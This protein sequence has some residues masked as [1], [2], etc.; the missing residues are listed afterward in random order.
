MR[1]GYLKSFT[2]MAALLTAGSLAAKPALDSG[3]GNGMVVQRGQPIIFSG[4]AKPS[5]TVSGQFGNLEASTTAGAD[6]SFVLSFPPHEASTKLVNLRVSDG[7][8]TEAVSGIMVGDVFLCS[9]Q[10]NMEFAVGR[11]LNSWGEMQRANDQK[12]RLRKIPK[13]TAGRPQRQV[14]GSSVWS[15]ADGSS[16]EDFSAACYY[17]GKRL[18]AERPDVPVGLIHSNWG[19]SAASAWL[20]PEA[21]EALY[22]KEPAFLLAQFQDD[23]R[24][25]LQTF[26]AVWF[27][28]WRSKDNGRT[29]WTDS[30][31][32]NW[33]AVPG[34]TDWNQ[35]K[36]SGLDKNPK[37]NVWLRQ[38]LTLTR[39]QAAAGG[40]LSLGALD[41]LDHTWVNGEVIGNTFG[42]GT[43]REY[44]LEAADLR[45][46]DNEIL[47]AVFNG[48]GRG[49]FAGSPSKIFFK[50]NNGGEAIA[51]RDGWQYSLSTVRGSPPR[52]PWDANAGLGVMHNAMIAPLG[53]MRLAGVA[54][55]QG[56]SD[57]GKGDYVPKLHALFDGWRGQFGEQTRML[58]VQ[59]ADFGPRNTSPVGS[60]WA[61]LR[62]DQL[63]AA[64]SDPNAEMVTALDIGEPTDIHPAN[65][66]VLG[67]RLAL[68]AMGKAM[69]MPVSASRDD[70]QIVVTFSGI[71]GDLRAY[72]GSTALGIEL[73]G[74]TQDSCKFALAKPA[75]QTL[76][77]DAA[78]G[79]EITRVRHGWSDAPIINLYDSRDIAVPGFE[80]SLS[81]GGR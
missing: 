79:E 1:L 28:W 21:I 56:E 72:G 38:R 12:L 31:S 6:G 34:P 27:D 7:A 42:W 20:V 40:M 45:E 17:M 75:G 64:Q 32:L 15:G 51:L 66:N 5:A 47:V 33:Q 57:V 23:P 14:V 8:G 26:S 46:G 24:A 60:G 67:E 69:P 62:Q 36:G 68:A 73:C 48:G 4:T 63:L 19:G 37:A 35:W 43:V 77:V 18:R 53:Q 16:I 76:I 59:L 70:T 44:P 61:E 13:A 52:A 71:E 30:S 39:E 74:A 11:A 9:G 29:P 55:Y 78:G 80:I 54:W 10:S 41:D 58:V 49:G 81:S 65:K 25:A 3:Y 2:A 50:P 22:G